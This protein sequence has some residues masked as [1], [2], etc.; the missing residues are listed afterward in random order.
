MTSKAEVTLKSELNTFKEW[1]E[2]QSERDNLKKA[3]LGGYKL[4]LGVNEAYLSDF[5]IQINSAIAPYHYYDSTQNSNKMGY[6][7]STSSFLEDIDKILKLNSE[8]EL[9]YWA[10]EWY[11]VIN[12]LLR[13][14]GEKTN[15]S[16][17]VS[18]YKPSFCYK[19]IN[20]DLL[21]IW[22]KKIRNISKQLNIFMNTKPWH[23]DGQAEFEL[24]KNMEPDFSL[25]EPS[26]EEIK[27]VHDFYENS[28]PDPQYRID[29]IKVIYNKNLINLFR[30]TFRGMQNRHNNPHFTS[31]SAP[32]PKKDIET[33]I[34]VNQTPE[35]LM[36]RENVRQ[37]YVKLQDA[38]RKYTDPTYP[39]VTILKLWNGHQLIESANN[40][41]QMGY[42]HVKNKTDSG[43]YGKGF[44]FTQ[45]VG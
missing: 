29:T 9:R 6:Y 25:R 28:S 4:S 15:L 11:K 22:F 41:A 5:L 26:P 18:D 35:E 2:Q 24:Y 8:A 39:N 31:S 27:L 44:Y 34:S 1:I 30:E 20:S 45:Q 23:F 21:D 43:Y 3:I 37:E 12:R 14:H 42:A 40:I 38:N 32:I 10:E 19:E 13:F 33:V 7:I 36:C 17:F 16:G